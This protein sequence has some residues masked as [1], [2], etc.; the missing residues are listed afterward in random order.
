[1]GCSGKLLRDSIRVLAGTAMLPLSF[2]STF[3]DVVM[4][5]SMSLADKVN[6]PLLI[7]NRKQSRIGMVLLVFNT[8]PIDFKCLNKDDADTTKFIRLVYVA[9]LRE[10][11]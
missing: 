11:L 1:M 9:K 7:S 8:P 2:E 10:V 6:S 3:I 5:V 4:V